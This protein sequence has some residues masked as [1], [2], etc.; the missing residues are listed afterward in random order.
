MRRIFLDTGHWIE[1]SRAANG[2][3]RKPYVDALPVLRFA[4][5]QWLASFP[6]TASHYIEFNTHGNPGPRRQVGQ[7]A[8]E[9]SRLHTIAPISTLLDAE[10][11]RAAAEAVGVEPP[12][13]VQ[14]FGVGVGHAFGQDFQGINLKGPGTIAPEH[15]ALLSARATELLEQELI[16]GPPFR[17]PAHGIAAPDRKFADDFAAT[18]QRQAMHLE[19]WGRTDDHAHRLVMAYEYVDL[20]DPLT[21]RLARHGIAFSEF[22]DQGRDFL[23]AFLQALPV[24]HSVVQLRRVAMR[25]GRTWEPND[26]H[27]LG[28]LGMASVH[29]DLVLFEKYW[30]DT[31]RQAGLDNPA[32]VV[33]RIE[34]LVE[35]LVV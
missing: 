24:R 33:M 18:S 1:L 8:G 34:D 19:E 23:D 31:Y 12:P 14:V 5:E 20:L 17:L 26:M 32:T 3:G 30:S 10:L 25:Q 21:E 4:S 35:L 13:P 29:C 28:T 6:L 9:L 22:L 15:L 16:G 7:L 27:D 11:D 2:I